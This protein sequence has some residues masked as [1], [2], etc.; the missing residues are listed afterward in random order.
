[1]KPL[2]NTLFVTLPESYIHREGDQV[3]VKVAREER[4]RLPIHTLS[5]IVCIGPV[6]VSPFALQLAAE[7]GVCVSFLTDNGRFMARVEG[8]VRGNV[9]LRREQYRRSDHPG[10]S[11]IL[12]R[13][14]IAA[15][16]A[17][18]RIVLQR[19][20]RDHGG[21]DADAKISQAIHRIARIAQQIE[22]PVHLDRLRGFEGEAAEAYFG[23]FDELIIAGKEHFQFRGRTRRP[24]LDPVNAILSF[25]YTLLVHDIRGALESVG[26]DPSVGF[27]HRDRPGRPSLALD[28]MEEFRPLLADRLVLTLINRQQLRPSGF[29]RTETGGWIMT[30]DTR[31]EVL[32]AWQKRKQEEVTHPWL[33]E[34][35]PMGLL[36]YTQALLLA[37]HLRGDY[38]TY[39]PFAWK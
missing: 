8:A 7:A 14:F 5:G 2:L 13:S 15:K 9:L 1:M 12:A 35:V 31:K 11:A 16:L 29:R 39:P 21:R 10:G 30:D 38:E 6:S 23:V 28:L 26:L 32:I 20:L 37:R 27:L 19:S 24:P 4:L 17:N 18:C 3:V 25:V 34:T 22:G 33:G 36:P